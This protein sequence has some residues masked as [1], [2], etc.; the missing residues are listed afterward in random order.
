MSAR[1]NRLFGHPQCYA[2]ELGDCSTAIS[3]EHYVSA[4]VLRGV[5]LGEPT[6]LVQNLSFQQPGTL[7]ER[8]IS[9]LAAKVLCEKHNA[10]LSVFDGAGNALF[11]G[12]DRMDSAA[13]KVGTPPE[14]FVVNGD[15]LERWMLK[16]L[17]GGLYSGTMPVPG[18]SMKGVC[19]PVEWLN[20]L[21]RGADL[22]AGQGLF[23]R[24]GTPGE[25]FS[26]EPAILKMAVVVD[27]DNIIIGFRMWV[28]NF[29]YTLV[30]ADL[31]PTPPPMLHHA[32][33]RPAGLVVEGSARSLH[34]E[35]GRPSGSKEVRVVWVGPS[36]V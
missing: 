28:F 23:L 17:C 16:M 20:V 24:A 35:W 5:S 9:S 1:S 15:H 31:P 29:E 21:F 34:F 7:E 14:T 27:K 3:K 26:T 12:M 6:V 25:V 13:G 11:V 36:P 4:V 33:Y 2:R 22:P 18:G 30:L 10:A 32:H 19:P 8:G